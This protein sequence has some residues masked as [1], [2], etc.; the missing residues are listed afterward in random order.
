MPYQIK[1]EPDGA[2]KYFGG[3]VS[4]RDL[5]DSEQEVFNHP[6]RVAFRYVISVY[7][8]AHE[9]TFSTQDIEHLRQLRAAGFNSNDRIKFAVVADDEAIEE[10]VRTQVAA[11]S[12]VN[13]IALF[14]NYNDAWAWATA[15][16][17]ADADGA[18]P[19]VAG[20]WACS[21]HEQQRLETLHCYGI[22]DSL[23]EADYDHIVLLASQICETPIAVISLVDAD[24][25]WFKAQVGLSVSETPRSQAFCAQAIQNPSCVMQVSDATLDPRFSD[26]PLVQ[27]RPDIRFY[28]GVPL[29]TKS[30]DALGTVCVIDQKP[31]TLTAS[32]TEALKVLGNLVMSMLDMRLEIASLKGAGS[33]GQ[34][35]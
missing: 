31:R 8:T 19:S 22:L 16:Q 18:A 23:P 26:N 20:E 24:R 13:P 6:D 10:S 5:I 29:L 3:I 35:R 32:Q 34:G 17:P 21:P 2:I 11:N 30:G 4:G 28:A 15:L 1:W 27:G 7:L 33:S 12:S 14:D 25:Q 9:V